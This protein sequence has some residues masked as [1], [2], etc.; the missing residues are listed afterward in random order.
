MDRARREYRDRGRQDV[1]E[2][3]PRGDRQTEEDG[4]EGGAQ[5]WRPGGPEE[6]QARRQPGTNLDAALRGK[7]LEVTACSGQTALVCD[8][9][10]Q[11]ELV[12]GPHSIRLEYETATRAGGGY[13]PDGNVSTLV[14]AT[15]RQRTNVTPCNADDRSRANLEAGRFAETDHSIIDLDVDLDIDVYGVGVRSDPTQDRVPIFGQSCEAG[16]IGGVASRRLVHGVAG[17]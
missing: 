13:A 9:R 5:E 8:R 3:R 1:E 14:E 15:A 7:G 2:A 17:G 12:P 4:H 6:Q 16:R 11:V 10:R